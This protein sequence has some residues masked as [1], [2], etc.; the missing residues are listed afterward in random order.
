MARI[1]TLVTELVEQA[2][3]IK[4]D[5]GKVISGGP[6]MGIA[7]FTLDVPVVKGMSGMLFLAPDEV[8]AQLPDPCIR[9]AHCVHSCP[10]KLVPTTIEKLVMAEKIDEAVEAGLLDCIECGSCAYVCPSR[11]RLV[12]YF[13]FGKYLA[14]ERRKAAAAAEKKEA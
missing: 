2:G 10:M 1:G 14:N 11:R 9:C 5:V 7:Q 3:G 12:H 4:G 8:H 6:M 13:K